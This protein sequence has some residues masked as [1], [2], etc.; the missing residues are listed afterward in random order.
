MISK[1]VVRLYFIQIFAFWAVSLSMYIPGLDLLLAG[2]FLVIIFIESRLNA[3]L[4]NWEN[5]VI[6]ALWQGPAI[7]LA[8]YTL[9]G[10]KFWSLDDYAIF[11]LQFWGAPLLPLWSLVNISVSMEYPL[12]YYL[13]LTAPISLF[14]YYLLAACIS[15]KN[16]QSVG[17]FQ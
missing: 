3:N 1:A 6:A 11:A 10:L 5:I 14:I 12:Y 13:I 9:A 4:S 8:L 7:L 2:I 15:L 17:G 16:K